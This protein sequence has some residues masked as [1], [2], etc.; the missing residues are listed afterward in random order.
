MFQGVELTR[1]LYNKLCDT[2]KQC[3]INDRKTV[4]KLF[5]TGEVHCE[6][7]GVVLTVLENPETSVLFNVLGLFYASCFQHYLS[8]T[9][10]EA[11]KMFKTL[12]KFGACISKPI[13]VTK[14]GDTVVKLQFFNFSN[15]TNS[16][17]IDTC[18]TRKYLTFEDT[19]Y[20]GKDGDELGKTILAVICKKYSTSVKQMLF[21]HKPS[22]KTVL[23]TME[24]KQRKVLKHY[25]RY[26][27]VMDWL[28]RKVLKNEWSDL[29]IN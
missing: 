5:E 21:K 1:V 19:K 14:Q 12:V 3:S 17:I 25:V 29:F 4:K 23:K 16:C 7:F 13:C 2:F 8:S 22:I 28:Q 27:C 18:L 6:D 9:E 24:G 10:H 26:T 15:L 20:S 11:S